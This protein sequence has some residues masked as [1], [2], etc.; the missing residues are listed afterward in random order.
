MLIMEYYSVVWKNELLVSTI[1][2]VN[3]KYYVSGSRG[4]RKVYVYEIH[5]RICIYAYD[6]LKKAILMVKSLIT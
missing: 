2:W 4:G 3:P 1:T 6:I 5:D